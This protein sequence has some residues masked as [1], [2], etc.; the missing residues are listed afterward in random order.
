MPPASPHTL[1]RE[2]I[3]DIVRGD[4]STG[5]GP[6]SVMFNGRHIVHESQVPL[7]EEM[8]QGDAAAMSLAL[9]ELEKLQKE[10]D[11]RR[12]VALRGMVGHLIPPS[13]EDP[14]LAADPRTA[15]HRMPADVA[16]SKLAA[17]PDAKVR[18]A[19]DVAK[20]MGFEGTFHEFRDQHRKALEAKSKREAEEAKAAEDEAKAKQEA[21]ATPAEESDVEGREQRLSEG[22]SGEEGAEDKP[23]DHPPGSGRRRGHR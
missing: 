8:A 2:Q 7:A 19:Y 9:G 11:R 5:R 22:E 12:E 10:L 3:L 4:P 23:G 14:T 1:S 17:D 15:R 13:D 16:A 6:A 18:A 20:D 21:E